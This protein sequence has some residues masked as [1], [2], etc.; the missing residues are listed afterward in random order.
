MQFQVISL[1]ICAVLSA[2]VAEVYFEEKFT[3][4]TYSMP[5]WQISIE[6]FGFFPSTIDEFWDDVANLLLRQVLQ[7]MS[8]ETKK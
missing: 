2:A 6:K 5:N 1:V 4:G 3:E 7:F 8:D